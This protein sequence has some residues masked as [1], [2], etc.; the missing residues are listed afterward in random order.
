MI[1]CPEEIRFTV[2]HHH[3]NAG[4]SKDFSLCEKALFFLAALD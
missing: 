3:R 1:I 2:G 4:F